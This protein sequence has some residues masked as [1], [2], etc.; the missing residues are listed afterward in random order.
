MG[1]L[2]LGYLESRAIHYRVIYF[3]VIFYR[4]YRAYKKKR[5]P[6][7]KLLMYFFQILTVLKW[8]PFF[9]TPCISKSIIYE[10]KEIRGIHRQASVVIILRHVQDGPR[11]D[12]LEICY[13]NYL[14]VFWLASLPRP[15]TNQLLWRC[16]QAS[17]VRE[18]W[19]LRWRLL[20]EY[21]G[22]RYRGVWQ[23]ET[24]SVSFHVVLTLF[25]IFIIITYYSC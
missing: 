10:N 24:A 4:L 20:C 11:W 19:R 25:A 5:Q 9:Y 2:E 21:F 14:D 13:T 18:M 7:K 6:L 12:R 3:I 1:Y 16:G 23:L 15:T 8:L 17:C 22:S